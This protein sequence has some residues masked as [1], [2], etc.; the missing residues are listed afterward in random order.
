MDIDNKTKNLLIQFV[1]S[2][3]Y[4]SYYDCRQLYEEMQRL[5]LGLKI[6]ELQYFVPNYEHIEM[7]KEDKIQNGKTVWHGGCQLE[8][9]LIVVNGAELKITD[10]T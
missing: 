5:G 3:F 7:I 9:S 2:A 6:G 1:T 10:A 4:E 8:H